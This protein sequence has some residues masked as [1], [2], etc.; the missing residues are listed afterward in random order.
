MA[1]SGSVSP[2]T[3]LCNEGWWIPFGDGMYYTDG[4]KRLEFRMGTPNVDAGRGI[5]RIDLYAQ[6]G[7]LGDGIDLFATDGQG[8]GC[9][10]GRVLTGARQGGC[11][12]NSSG[13][14]VNCGMRFVSTWQTSDPA[15]YVKSYTDLRGRAQPAPSGNQQHYLFPSYFR[16]DWYSAPLPRRRQH[17]LL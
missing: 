17:V 9:F 11:G 7:D 4:P 15:Q 6:I 5:Y 13:G 1:T 12:A 14:A 2:A 16:M 8:L 10:G 3:E